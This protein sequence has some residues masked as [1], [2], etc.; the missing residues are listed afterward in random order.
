MAEGDFLLFFG[1]AAMALWR[2]VR[3]FHKIGSAVWR[4]QD[5]WLCER[6]SCALD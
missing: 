5:G 4:V 3:D 1:F 6:V 2:F